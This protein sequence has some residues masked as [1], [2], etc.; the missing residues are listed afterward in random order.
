MLEL[1]LDPNRA[2]AMLAGRT[3]VNTLKR[4][5]TV[6]QQWRL[7]LL[8][9]KQL[10]PPGRPSDLVDYVLARRDEPCGKRIP[11]LIMKAICCMEQVAG[12]LG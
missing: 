1:S 7:W 9:T 4:Y 12:Y 2:I 10:A 5:V 8:E 6:F 3:R 11:E